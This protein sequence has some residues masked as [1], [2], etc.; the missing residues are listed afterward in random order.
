[1]FVCR[2]AA[3]IRC[4]VIV[5]SVAKHTFNTR[6][7]VDDYLGLVLRVNKPPF[8]WVNFGT[9]SGNSPQSGRLHL[10]S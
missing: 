5:T 6:R 9:A 2:S 10:T 7:R 8:A 4:N 3:G 1:M